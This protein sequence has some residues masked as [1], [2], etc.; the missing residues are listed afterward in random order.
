MKW[1]LPF[2]LLLRSCEWAPAAVLLQWNASAHATEYRV[3]LGTNAQTY[4][5]TL[6]VTEPDGFDDLLPPSSITLSNLPPGTWY[7]A[8]TAHRRDLVTAH[9]TETSDRYDDPSEISFA[10]VTPM[11]DVTVWEADTI[12]T[13]RAL[14]KPITTVRVPR[15]AATPKFLMVS[16]V[17][18]SNLQSPI[19]DLKFA[20]RATDFG[21]RAG[22][23][24]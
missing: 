1:L 8:V 2:L 18:V 23:L 4:S 17:P 3:H 16:A 7:A 24:Q 5:Q 14:W 21:S 6:V 20:A 19:A 15:S 11:L 9:W 10:V 13:P 22:K 12:N